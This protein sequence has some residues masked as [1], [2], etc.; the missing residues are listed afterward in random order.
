MAEIVIL[1]EL[2]VGS[3]NDIDTTELALLLRDVKAANIVD[4]ADYQQFQQQGQ[5]YEGSEYEEY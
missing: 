2:P 4:Y 5:Q 3:A 1:V